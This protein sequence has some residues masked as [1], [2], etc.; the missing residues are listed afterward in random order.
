[1]SLQPLHRSASCKVRG[2]GP[3]TELLLPPPPSPSPG[4]LTAEERWSQEP[5]AHLEPAGLFRP[6]GSGCSV[7]LRSKTV[8]GLAR[9]ASTRGHIPFHP[10]CVYMFNICFWLQ[11]SVS[12]SDHSRLSR[13]FTFLCRL[14]PFAFESDFFLILLYSIAGK[15]QIVIARCRLKND[16]LTVVFRDA[17]ES[18]CHI[19]RLLCC[20]P[21]LTYSLHRFLGWNLIAG[22]FLLFV[23]IAV[24]LGAEKGFRVMFSYSLN[25]E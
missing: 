20:Y 22:D 10:N 24:V 5:G 19:F 7:D 18:C 14:L 1:M 16:S 13:S 12:N 3:L 23:V 11:R 2:G 8:C 4:P 25:V 6:K 9:R 15:K 17:V 21:T